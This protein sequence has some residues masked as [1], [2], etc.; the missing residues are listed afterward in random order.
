M[1]SPIGSIKTGAAHESDSER[2][3][4]GCETG[5]YFFGYFGFQAGNL[6]GMENVVLGTFIKCRDGIAK[7]MASRRT[8][9]AASFVVAF[10]TFLI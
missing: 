2:N 5:V 7:K 9:S 6:V 8:S 1:C 4:F 3:L 10:S